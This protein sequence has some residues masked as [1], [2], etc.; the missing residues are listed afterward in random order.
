[1]ML[2]MAK[3]TKDKTKKKMGRPATG[4]GVQLSVRLQPAALDA[5][6]NYRRHQPD[7]PTRPEAVRRLLVEQLLMGGNAS[8][9]ELLQ[10]MLGVVIDNPSVIDQMGSAVM[11]LMKEKNLPDPRSLDTD[12]W[13]TKIKAAIQSG[14]ADD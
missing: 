7:I 13:I 8:S 12:D 1:M 6:D 9:V 4:E 3:K 14:T 5:L 11:Q 2:N 10:A